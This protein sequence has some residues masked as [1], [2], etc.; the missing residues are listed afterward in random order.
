[1]GVPI[2]CK[3]YGLEHNN[4]SIERHN[5][6]FK[7]RYRVTRGFKSE[8]MGEAFTELRRILKN[9]FYIFII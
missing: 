4:N 2:A 8:P 9:S 6:D 7:Q 5:E 3:K 1:F